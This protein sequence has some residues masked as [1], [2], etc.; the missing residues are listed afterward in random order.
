MHAKTSPSK[1]VSFPFFVFSINFEL[2]I[3]QIISVDARNHG[4]SPHTPTHSYELMAE[5]VAELIRTLELEKATLIGHSMGGRCMAYV[6]L[7]Y[8]NLFSVLLKV[9]KIDVF[10]IPA[11]IS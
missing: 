8:V 11:R 6:A 10:S 3:L 7:K 2:K 5:D 9:H 1:R 4:E